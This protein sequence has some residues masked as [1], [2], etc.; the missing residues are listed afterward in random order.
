MDNAVP[1]KDHELEQLVGSTLQA[2]TLEEARLIRYY[3]TLTPSEQIFMRRAILG[4]A[5][6]HNS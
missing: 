3:R 1:A 5:L 2:L 6:R 4:F